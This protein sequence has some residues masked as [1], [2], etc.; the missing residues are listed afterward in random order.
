MEILPIKRQGEGSLG[1]CG[2]PTITYS[3]GKLHFES[4]TEGA[5]Y[6]YTLSC[7]DVT[8]D[9]YSENG[10]IG[11]NASYIITAY[12]IADDYSAS[13]DATATL[14]WVNGNLE[15]TNINAAKMR[16][17]LASSQDGIVAISGLG[18]GEMVSLYTVD[19][20]KIGEATAVDGVASYAVGNIPIVIA[21]VGTS[22]I[23]IAV[24]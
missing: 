2:K 7:G 16:G 15:T 11:L 19:G 3:N 12:A 20:K 8:T 4:N 9:A 24:K 23:K 10:E 14:Y 22:S 18:N 13:D 6:H 1:K 21:K 17:V 5:S